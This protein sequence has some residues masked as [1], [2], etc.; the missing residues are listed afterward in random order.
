MAALEGLATR[1]H[2]TRAKPA[3][4]P[5]QSSRGAMDWG[6]VRVFLAIARQGSMRGAGRALGLSQ[7]TIARR[8]AAFEAGFTGQPLFDCISTRSAINSSPRP[9]T[10]SA[11]C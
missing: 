4:R 2:E 10:P 6:D 5:P 1:G 7:P 8:L 9:K 11:Q 3:A